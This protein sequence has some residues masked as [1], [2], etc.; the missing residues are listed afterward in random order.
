MNTLEIN[1][2]DNDSLKVDVSDVL[3]SSSVI[4]DICFQHYR[5]HFSSKKKVGQKQKGPAL[6]VY[7]IQEILDA[8]LKISISIDGNKITYKNFIYERDERFSHAL[9][10]IRF[11]DKNRYALL[12]STSDFQSENFFKTDKSNSNKE[13]IRFTKGQGA[14]RFCHVLLE[15]RSEDEGVFADI[16]IETQKG[17]SNHVLKKMFETLINTIEEH[18]VSEELFQEV[19]R[20]DVTKKTMLA[21]D[22]KVNISAISDMTLLNKIKKGDFLSI[23]IRDKWLEHPNEEVESLEEI[24]RNIVLR[25][26]SVMEKDINLAELAKGLRKTASKL[27]KG[28]TRK[29]QKEP[30]FHVKYLDGNHERISPIDINDLNKAT[31]D[32]IVKKTWLNKFERT[33]ILDNSDGSY[34]DDKLIS[35]LIKRLEYQSNQN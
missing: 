33:P 3:L 4:Q 22:V 29:L 2:Y 6:R 30:T 23:E 31:T 34:V 19:Y 32:M 11:I 14:Q 5:L 10:E 7:R 1:N 26:K 20:P 9:E 25:P 13:Y 16:S 28:K 15:I 27:I 21:L 35:T 17:V 8:I 12:I 18:Q 24:E